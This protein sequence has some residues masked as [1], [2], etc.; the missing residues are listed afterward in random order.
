LDNE[1]F[2]NE[3]IKRYFL[4]EVNAF[5]EEVVQ[6]IKNGA[7]L[8][9]ALGGRFIKSVHYGEEYDSFIAKNVLLALKYHK[10]DLED[11]I[12][13]FDGVNEHLNDVRRDYYERGA[14]VSAVI[15]E[16]QEIAIQDFMEFNKFKGFI[17]E[18]LLKGKDP[19]E[20]DG[21]SNG[22]VFKERADEA[23][24]GA[25]DDVTNVDVRFDYSWRPRYIQEAIK[26]IQKDKEIE[27][28][29]ACFVSI[30]SLLERSTKRVIERIS[31]ECFSV[32][33]EYQ[34]DKIDSIDEYKTLCLI[35]LFTCNFTTLVRHSTREFHSSKLSLGMRLLLIETFTRLLDLI[36]FDDSVK[37][38][39]AFVKEGTFSGIKLGNSA[40]IHNTKCFLFRAMKRVSESGKIKAL[41]NT[42]IKELQSSP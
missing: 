32:I 34:G 3:I 13:L 20:N 18:S 14:I 15:M 2:E 11:K 39:E 35:K 5:T 31:L 28:V 40:L 26:I 24:S 10:V 4:D 8:I 9:K 41:V 25:I 29:K 42:T 36:S 19:V 6:K 7:K 16:S 1:E 33:L 23:L 21:G 30:P 17:P 38:V 22:N 12:T 37:M 27:K